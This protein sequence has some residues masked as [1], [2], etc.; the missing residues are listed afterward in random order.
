MREGAIP[1]YKAENDIPSVEVFDCLGRYLVGLKSLTEQGE[2][3]INFSAV[4]S[5]H[6]SLI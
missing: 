5:P 1:P 6:W 2:T 3:S 4:K